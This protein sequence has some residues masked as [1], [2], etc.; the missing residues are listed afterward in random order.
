MLVF[1]LNPEKRALQPKVT[2][3]VILAA[4]AHWRCE[5]VD[6]AIGERMN[7]LLDAYNE[8][9]FLT[10]LAGERINA[11]FPIQ[12]DLLGAQWDD[13][14][15]CLRPAIEGAQR[16]P[17]IWR[18]AAV[19][20]AGG[21][22]DCDWL[23][24]QSMVLVDMMNRL[25][26]SWRVGE[27]PSA[28]WQSAGGSPRPAAW[29]KA[30]QTHSRIAPLLASRDDPTPTTTAPLFTVALCAYN[31]A[32]TLCWSIRSVL[33]QTDED[34]ELLVVNDGSNDETAEVL[35]RLPDDARIRILTHAL[36]QGKARSLNET[37]AASRGAWLLE[38]DADDWLAADCLSRLRVQIAHADD[39]CGLWFA[40]HDE[41]LERPDGE[42]IFRRTARAMPE[43][44]EAAL[45]ADAAPLAPRLY[46]TEALRQLGGWREQ[47]PFGGRLY[48]DFQ[49]I[50]RLARVFPVRH[51]PAVLYHRRLRGDSLTRT[52][53]DQ[54]ALWKS[55]FEQ[56]V[57]QSELGENSNV[58]DVRRH[59]A[60]LARCLRIKVL[61][62]LH[63]QRS[64]RDVEQDAGDE[65]G[66]LV[67]LDTATDDHGQSS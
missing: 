25:S 38:L 67:H 35:G 50:V 60:D 33:A 8:P 42:P 27:L 17:V 46:W 45:L 18:A 36:N 58:V 59:D 66:L 16:G 62:G 54:Y 43:Y 30:T 9:F 19:V 3:N 53:L 65:L 10:L 2:Q 55:W 29:R 20:G 51:V 47:D 26:S 34:W 31:D 23:P 61:D 5:I 21:F 63:D 11:A 44:D 13:R 12:L 4:S 24:F 56:A 14:T 49:M 6:G 7:A 48:E 52:N 39:A 41:W 15:A 57:R 64:G 32:A 1:I 40:D 37:L 28:W 22:A